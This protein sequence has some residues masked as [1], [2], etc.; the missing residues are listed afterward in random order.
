MKRLQ[1]SARRMEQRRQDSKTTRSMFTL[2]CM[3]CNSA[4]NR[5]GASLLHLAQL[6]GSWVQPRAPPSQALAT[7]SLGSASSQSTGPRSRGSVQEPST[8]P[9]LRLMVS[10]RLSESSTRLHRALQQ[11]LSSAKPV[12]VTITTPADRPTSALPPH[13]AQTACFLGTSDPLGWGC[14]VI[15]QAFGLWQ[16]SWHG[17]R[18]SHPPSR[19]R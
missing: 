18:P 3:S 16:R 6:P 12:L 9:S 5:A 2:S 10:G 17:G 11:T 13:G 14:G 15:A 1:R 8:C 4:S 19:V 7:S